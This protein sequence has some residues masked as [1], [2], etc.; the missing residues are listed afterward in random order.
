VTTSTPCT[1]DGQCDTTA[2]HQR[3]AELALTEIDNLRAAFA[4]SRERED[5]EAA[6]RLVPSLQPLWLSRGRIME[7][8]SWYYAVLA[9]DDQL[10]VDVAPAVCAGAMA[11]QAMLMSGDLRLE[12]PGP[13]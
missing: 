4:W 6:L 12:P 5:T 1:W 9:D 8:L 13:T 3:R 7:G 11:D 10:A 2:G